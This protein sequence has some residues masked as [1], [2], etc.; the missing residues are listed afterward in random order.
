[1]N[2]NFDPNS[3]SNEFLGK[4]KKYKKNN[5]NILHYLKT[6]LFNNIYG[7]YSK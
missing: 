6:L 1:M 7:R 5:F 3:I 2:Y 4:K